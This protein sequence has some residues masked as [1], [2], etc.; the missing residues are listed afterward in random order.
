MTSARTSSP[1]LAAATSRRSS[2]GCSGKASPGSKI[3]NVIVPVRVIYRHA[4]ERDEV[5]GEPDIRN[6]HP[7]ERVEAPCYRAQP[8][9]RPP[10]CSPRCPPTTSALR[11]TAFYGGLRRRRAAR[12]PVGG[13]YVASGRSASRNPGPLRA[14]PSGAEVGEGQGGP[15]ARS[16]RSYATAS[17]TSRPPAAVTATTSSSGRSGPTHSRRPT[18]GSAPPTLWK[19]RNVQR[20]EPLLAP[21]APSASADA[22][23]VAA[24]AY[25]RDQLNLSDASRASWEATARAINVVPRSVPGVA[26]LQPIGLHECRHTFVS[27]DARCRDLARSH[28][29]P[30]RHTSSVYMTDRYR[31]L[32]AGAE[33]EAPAASTSTSLGPTPLAESSSS[34]RSSSHEDRAILS[35]SVVAAPDFWDGPVRGSNGAS[36]PCQRTHR[37]QAPSGPRI[38]C[39]PQ[40]TAVRARRS[41]SSGGGRAPLPARRRR[42]CLHEQR[43]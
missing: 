27:S 7:P 36:P 22:L 15:P 31:H 10:S 26:L 11:A 39:S 20:V 8:P 17:P 37:H 14:G 12:A 40:R 13:H 38:F 4:L 23:R 29:R 24:T 33:R 32:L 25:V 9:P 42:G 34:G 6:R 41:P 30:R 1:T 18:S 16:L 5:S 3:R 21:L 19:A 2:T 28:R 43:T 35:E